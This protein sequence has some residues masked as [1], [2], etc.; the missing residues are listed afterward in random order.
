[1]LHNRECCTW[2]WVGNRGCL[3]WHWV[4]SSSVERADESMVVDSQEAGRSWM[5]E[6][7]SISS[8]CRGREDTM[9]DYK[10]LQRISDKGLAFKVYRHT[11]YMREVTQ[12]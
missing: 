9:N 3:S 10:Q 4:D 11:Y 5:L 6:G 2:H 1:M 7:V 8:S 12:L